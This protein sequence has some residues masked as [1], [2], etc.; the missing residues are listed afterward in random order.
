MLRWILGW[1]H[2]ILVLL[3]FWGQ[4][5]RESSA[6]I[7]Q[8]KNH[9]SLQCLKQTEHQEAPLWTRCQI[10]FHKS[11]DVFPSPQGHCCGSSPGHHCNC[12]G[13]WYSNSQCGTTGDKQK[14]QLLS[15]GHKN[16]TTTS[17]KTGRGRHGKRHHIL[18]KRGEMAVCNY[19]ES[20]MKS[21]L[22]GFSCHKVGA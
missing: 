14:H 12:L 18:G 10:A 2:K 4:S 5:S 15:H 21:I 9:V 1:K 22:A 8:I 3:T 19:M 16:A 11:E 17:W 6:R 7:R 13:V 20:P